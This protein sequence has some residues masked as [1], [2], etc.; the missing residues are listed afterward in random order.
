MKLGTVAI[1]AGVGALGIA[2]LYVWRKGS[3]NAAGQSLGTAAVEAASGVVQG[4]GQATGQV[5]TQGVGAVGSSV[6]LPTPSETVDDARVVRWIIDNVGYFEGSKWGTAAAFWSALMMADGSGVPP[7]AGSAAALAFG[8]SASS[9]PTGTY[10]VP[11]YTG[12]FSDLASADWDPMSI[13]GTGS[14]H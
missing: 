5:F 2:A 4:I 1:L 10:V 3:L 9:T 14:Y 6:G 11:E 13:L 8:R 7:P 12:S